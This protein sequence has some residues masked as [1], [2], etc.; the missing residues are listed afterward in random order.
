MKKLN[1]PSAT[2]V[3]LSLERCF[4]AS[5]WKVVDRETQ[6]SHFR[7]WM[8]RKGEQVNLYTKQAELRDAVM[9][10]LKEAKISAITGDIQK[11]ENWVT[12]LEWTANIVDGHHICISVLRRT[13]E[14]DKYRIFRP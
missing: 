14:G 13:P 4:G 11:L 3:R 12:G 8:R 10:K 5:G 7:T 1:R 6:E 9:A 2:N